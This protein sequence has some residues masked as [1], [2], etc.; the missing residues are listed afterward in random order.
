MISQYLISYFQSRI[1]RDR[2]LE[3]FSPQDFE[4]IFQFHDGSKMV[5]ENQSRK[6]LDDRVEKS[7]INKGKFASKDS[8]SHFD[9]LE[10]YENVRFSTTYKVYQMMD[11]WPTFDTIAQYGHIFSNLIII[12]VS[13]YY[14]VSFFMLFNVICVCYFYAATAIKLQ[15]RA[16]RSY[17]NSGLQN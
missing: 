6:T 8:C 15:L 4:K 1:Q 7:R 14:N 16:T 13:I 12:L 11:W 10:V 5:S 3:A 17:L 2:G 9:F